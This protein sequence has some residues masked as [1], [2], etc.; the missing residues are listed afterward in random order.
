LRVV[1]DGISYSAFAWLAAPYTL[2]FSA[3]IGGDIGGLD[4]RIRP[5]SEVRLFPLS[6]RVRARRRGACD[7]RHMPTRG[8]AESV[9]ALRRLWNVDVRFAVLE[10]RYIQS[11]P[12]WKDNGLPLRNVS[13]R[14][15]EFCCEM[16][17]LTF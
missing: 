7:L 15:V 11:S 16:G 2:G 6:E 3:G 10:P 1:V 12:P 13:P 4:V 9:C 14:F 17:L 5:S 8:E